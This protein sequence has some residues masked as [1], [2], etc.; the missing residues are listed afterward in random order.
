MWGFFVQAIEFF[1]HLV[2]FPS[3]FTREIDVACLTFK[4]TCICWDRTKVWCHIYKTIYNKHILKN[5]QPCL[6]LTTP[7]MHGTRLVMY[8]FKL[9]FPLAHTNQSERTFSNAFLGLLLYTG[10]SA[11]HCWKQQPWYVNQK[12]P[13]DRSGL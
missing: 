11:L 8:W 1:I 3:F 5:I 6:L 10:K 13:G 9:E 2:D 12:S 7:K 4:V